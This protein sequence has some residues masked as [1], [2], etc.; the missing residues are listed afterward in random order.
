MEMQK[1][2]LFYKENRIFVVHFLD[3]LIKPNPFDDEIV[4]ENPM[5]R[6]FLAQANFFHKKLA[7]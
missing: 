5:K 4:A 1:H 2:A 3:T 6:E 7:F